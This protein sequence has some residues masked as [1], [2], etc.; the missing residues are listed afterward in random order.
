M[1]IRR[2]TLP[3]VALVA[4]NVVMDKNANKVAVKVLGNQYK[5]DKKYILTETELK[6]GMESFTAPGGGNETGHKG[7]G[8][9]R[10]TKIK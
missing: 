9:A 5:L 10:I 1:L 4:T 8:F 3:I 2:M 7:D 6:S